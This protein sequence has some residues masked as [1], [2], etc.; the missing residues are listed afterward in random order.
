MGRSPIGRRPIFEDRQ[1]C[2]ALGRELVRR[3]QITA[4][5]L[6]EATVLSTGSLCLDVRRGNGPLSPRLPG[7]AQS[8]QGNRLKA[9]ERSVRLKL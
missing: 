9:R 1:A 8:S 2:A 3:E 6:C 7:S 5:C 4:G